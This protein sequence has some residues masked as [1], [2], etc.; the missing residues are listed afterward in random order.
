MLVVTCPL[1]GFAHTQAA[2]QLC[3]D[4]ASVGI[5][6]YLPD[7]ISN[8]P[9]V[10]SATKDW[11]GWTTAQIRRMQSC[12]CSRRLVGVYPTSGHNAPREEVDAK[13][14][15]S[16]GQPSVPPRVRGR[17]PLHEDTEWKK[18]PGCRWRRHATD[19]SHTRV[20][21]ECK[22]PFTETVVWPRATH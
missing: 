22:F 12:I 16:N 7:N 15:E 17:K 11:R 18:C 4:Q 9:Q 2:K 21:N 10:K 6:L 14:P 5:F 8:C 3:A 1:E 13:E 20:P 19:V